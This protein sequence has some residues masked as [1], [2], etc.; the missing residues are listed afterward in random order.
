MDV[1]FLRGLH[2]NYNAIESKDQG[3]FYITGLNENSF[4]S[5][6]L[7]SH[8]LGTTLASGIVLTGYNLGEGKSSSANIEA[9]DSVLSAIQKLDLTLNKA[10]GGETAV[11]SFGEKV[12]AI[13]ISSAGEGH[14]VAFT[15]NGNELQANVDLSHDHDDVYQKIL[16]AGDFISIN[17][18]N[19]IRTVQ[20]TF[21]K[22]SDG[23]LADK[24]LVTNET[25]KSYVESYV[26]IVVGN[27]VTKEQLT[28]TLNDYVKTVSLTETLKG[29]ATAEQGA[30]A[31]TAVQ[32]VTSGASRGAIAVD[33]ND[34]FVTGLGSAAFED[35][36]SFQPTLTTGDFIS[37]D[38]N[39]NITTV[40]GSFAT[41]DAEKVEGLATV[42]AVETYVEAQ[43]ETIT[44]VLTWGSF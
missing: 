33:G 15:M 44:A 22:N 37:I 41:A 11:I 28:S 39:N 2:A 14:N 4:D 36:T 5:I 10:I 16:T 35:A 19:T 30:K 20:G 3:T 13:T 29:Y 17:E 31:D 43:I 32:S 38:K 26:G 12:G 40:Q 27:Y 9:T 1:K 42:G 7:G 8:L 34:V 21:D 25:V 24:G 23:K 18:D 6:Y